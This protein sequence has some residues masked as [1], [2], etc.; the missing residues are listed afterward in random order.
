MPLPNQSNTAIQTIRSQ[1]QVLDNEKKQLLNSSFTLTDQDICDFGRK[2]FIKL[3][4]F[5]SLKTV[6]SLSMIMDSQLTDNRATDS[7][8]NLFNRTQYDFANNNEGVLVLFQD[9]GISAELTRLTQHSLLYTQ[10][11]G[12]EL[13]KNQDIGLP[14]HVDTISFSFHPMEDF[15]CSLWI[16]TVPIRP[17]D[18]GGGLS[19]VAK[20]IFSG[21]CMFQY[22]EILSS[23]AQRLKSEGNP[24]P[25]E[26]FL[27]LELLPI[28]TPEMIDLLDEQA[29]TFDYEVG[30]ALLF[31]KSVIHR[32]CPLTEGPISTRG[33]FTFR[34]VDAYSTY[35]LQRAKNL[36]ALQE[37]LNYSQQTVYSLNIGKTD[38]EPLIDSP[39][40]ADTRERRVLHQ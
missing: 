33:A 35:D 6:D 34:F 25:Y 22:N 10:S 26:E 15:G 12:F 37:G 16:P 21:M 18:Q 9:P 27:K 38:G 4:N 36:I 7:Y 3:K 1:V 20:D 5:L 13:K 39:L 23:H 29:E 19:C 32:S 28:G 40:F 11:V 8:G 17:E 2:G 31:E 14:W 30:D 24:I